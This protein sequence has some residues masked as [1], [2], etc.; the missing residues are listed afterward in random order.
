[1]RLRTKPDVNGPC[2]DVRFRP[3][4]TIAAGELRGGHGTSTFG[5]AAMAIRLAQSLLQGGRLQAS[6][7]HHSAGS[8]SWC[9]G[10]RLGEPVAGIWPLSVSCT[11]LPTG[12]HR[13]SGSEGRVFRAIAGSG[14]WLYRPDGQ[15]GS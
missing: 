11:A 2:A 8:A 15:G 6:R 9:L 1:M 7:S 14:K 12:L 13:P 10:D 4:S 3:G 5:I